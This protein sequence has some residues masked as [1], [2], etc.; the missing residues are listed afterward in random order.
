MDFDNGN[1]GAAA[2]DNAEGG[3]SGGNG[4]VLNAF[5]GGAGSG[6]GAAGAGGGDG[7]ASAAAG[8]EGAGAESGQEP[9]FFANLSREVRDGESASDYDWAKA[10]GIKDEASLARI[11]RDNQKALRDSG[12]VKV[13]AEGASAEEIKAFHTAIGV[14]DDP[15]GYTVPEI[16]GAD[17]KPVPLNTELID[18]ITKAAHEG[19][20]PKGAI[21]HVL[22]TEIEHQLAEHDAHVKQVQDKANAHI[23][24][25]GEEREA[26]LAQ[27]NAAAKEAGLTPQDMEYL[28]GLPSGPEKML[29]ALAKFGTN[30]SEARLI[31]GEKQR[32]GI[33]AESAQ[34]EIDQIVADPER[35]D[36]AMTPGTA[37]YERYQ[38]LNDAVG[39]A[40]DRKAVENA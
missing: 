5:T 2:A 3:D 24:G 39:A 6:D 1:S 10:S 15:S 25:W 20:A 31:Q 19:G 30:F 16:K 27:V 18:R 11:A 7:G 8:D 28:R 38:R 32:F 14:P 35:R 21:E 29:D 12:R 37:E 23:K 22:K 40:A 4:D 13:P 17:G 36:K 9:A 26:K 33:D 34:K